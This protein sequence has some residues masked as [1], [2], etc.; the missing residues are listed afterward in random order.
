MDWPEPF[1]YRRS[2]SSPPIQGAESGPVVTEV[3]VELTAVELAQ[4]QLR[5]QEKQ[6]VLGLIPNFY[7]SY[8]PDAAPLAPR[9]KF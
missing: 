7:V 5:E 1:H 3:R 9:Q 4:G 8:L 2:L 6:R